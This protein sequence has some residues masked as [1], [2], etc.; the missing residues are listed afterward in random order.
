MKVD[1]NVFV[2]QAIEE[3]IAVRILTNVTVPRVTTVGHVMIKSMDLLVTA[4]Q[5]TTMGS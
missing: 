5:V 2:S 3:M 1:T 4:Y